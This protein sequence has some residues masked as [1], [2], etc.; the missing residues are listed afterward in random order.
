VAF[1]LS[2][3]TDIRDLGIQK[4]DSHEFCREEAS[5]S[6]VDMCQEKLI[7][8]KELEADTVLY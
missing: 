2:R 4:E 7:A 6:A 1:K 8:I 3:N 5:T